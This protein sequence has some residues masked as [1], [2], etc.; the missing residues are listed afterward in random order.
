[1]RVNLE[2]VDI[3]INFQHDRDL[4]RDKDQRS[5]MEIITGSSHRQD[6]CL[7]HP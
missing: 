4:D 6:P 5:W 7:Y 3:I 1:M 2:R